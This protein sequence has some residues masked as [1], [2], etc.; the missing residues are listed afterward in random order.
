MCVCI[1]NV[2]DSCGRWRP[3]DAKPGA[4]YRTG[5]AILPTRC[6]TPLVLLTPSRAASPRAESPRAVYPPLSRCLHRCGCALIA[7]LATSAATLWPS[8]RGHH[9]YTCH[10]PDCSA[11]AVRLQPPE[12]CHADSE[13]ARWRIW[14]QIHRPIPWRA[15]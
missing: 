7:L 12:H 2:R 1:F 15:G 4:D 6:L 5:R 10:P 14:Q 11:S 9:Q 3:S 13:P 8:Q